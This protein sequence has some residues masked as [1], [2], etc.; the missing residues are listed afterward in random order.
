MPYHKCKRC[1][2]EWD[3]RVKE[4]KCCP[5]CRQRQD[6]PQENKKADKNE[7]TK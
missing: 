4:P 6:W 1:N 5:R 2:Y 7:R 3:S